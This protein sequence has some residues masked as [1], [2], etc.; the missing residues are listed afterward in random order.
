MQHSGQFLS[1]AMHVGGLYLPS[2]PRMGQHTPGQALLI[3]SALGGT[4]QVLISFSP[5]S[6][7]FALKPLLHLIPCLLRALLAFPSDRPYALS[8]P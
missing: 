5:S 1:F 2:L 8:S 6:L 4:R 7:T 3:S